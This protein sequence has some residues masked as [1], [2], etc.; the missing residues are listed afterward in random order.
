LSGSRAK[1]LRNFRAQLR[2]AL[3]DLIVNED[4]V[5]WRIEMPD[6]LVFVDRGKA[7]SKSQRRRLDRINPRS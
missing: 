7:A 3:D 1:A 2:L 4:I 6:D 5:D